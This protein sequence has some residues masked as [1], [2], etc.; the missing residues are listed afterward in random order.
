MTQY[1]SAPP[2]ALI[3]LLLLCYFDSGILIE[4]DLHEQVLS[5]TLQITS[6]W[7]T[8]QQ[9]IEMYCDSVFDIAINDRICILKDSIF[10]VVSYKRTETVPS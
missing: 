5:S 8:Y 7:L 4:V 6:S 2:P 9:L 10:A 3:I 1:G